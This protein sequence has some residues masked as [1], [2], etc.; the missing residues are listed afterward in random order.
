MPTNVLFPIE[1]PW[2][3]ALCPIVHPEPI[4]TSAPLSTWIT[5]FSW[6]FV[7]SPIT[8]GSL[9]PLITAP[10]QIPTLVPILTLPITWAVS[11]IQKS[12]LGKDGYILFKLYI[13]MK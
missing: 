9:S 1:Q 3:I 6:I 7:L 2:I 11:E 13:A 8:I 12:P 10:N 4:L 5:V